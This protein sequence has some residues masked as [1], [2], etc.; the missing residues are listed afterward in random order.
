MWARGFF[1]DKYRAMKPPKKLYEVRM[2]YDGRPSS[3]YVNLYVIGGTI[4]QNMMLI[5][6]IFEDGE[7]TGAWN[8]VLR[9]QEKWKS[10]GVM[11]D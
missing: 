3:R 1:V 9:M 4:S 8:G 5:S 6:Q 2:L 10:S 11:L 7:G